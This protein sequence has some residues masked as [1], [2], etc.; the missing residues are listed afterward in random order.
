M[1][2]RIELIAKLIIT[3]AFLLALCFLLY[4]LVVLPVNGAEKVNAI[5][6]LLGW[7]ATIYAPIA[8]FFLLD[9]W[10]DQKAYE[11]KKEYISL[12]LHDL[13]PIFSKILIISTNTSNIEKVEK[14][15]VIN[16]GYLD[17]NALALGNDV[18]NLFAN[19]K[20]FS[21][22]DNNSNILELYNDFEMHIFFI[23][24]L[25]KTVIKRYKNYYD[26][27][28]SRRNPSQDF[29]I[30]IFRGYLDSEKNSLMNHILH[31]KT[32]IESKQKYMK[33]TD[34]GNTVNELEYTL[35]E[36]IESTLDIHDKIQKI[37]LDTFEP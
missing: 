22:I 7:S 14:F 2:K 31:L 11:L 6:G 4:G 13:R 18:T 34:A 12:V 27:F 19:I 24:F 16:K 8:A 33:K 9:N 21:K 17:Y 32:Y 29:D 35:S 20:V 23:D 28:T 37:L 15:L 25:Y 26:E 3:Y 5:I 10:K 36:L 1:N 30:D